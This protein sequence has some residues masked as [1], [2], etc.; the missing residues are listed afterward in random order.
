MTR[1]RV[2]LDPAF[3][4]DVLRHL[5]PEIKK[6]L[7]EALRSLADDPTGRATRRDVKGLDTSGELPRLF[8][9]RHG[10]WRAV[11]ALQGGDVLVLRIFH[12]GDG[13]GWMERTDES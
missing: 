1:S 4:A 2:R 10:E 7:R 8:R 9:L 3:A 13:Y 12:R 5:P 11:F 6:P